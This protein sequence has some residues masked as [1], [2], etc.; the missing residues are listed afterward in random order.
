MHIAAV[1]PLLATQRPKKASWTLAY[2]D[3][4]VLAT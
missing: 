1:S 2:S 3:Q 4:R